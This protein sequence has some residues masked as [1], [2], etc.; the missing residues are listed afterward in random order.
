MVYSTPK[1]PRRRTNPDSSQLFLRI[2]ETLYGVN[3]LPCHPEV[4]GKAFQLYKDD[5]TRY[6]VVRTPHGVA[7]D[8]PDFVYRRAGLDPAGCKHVRALVRQGLLDDVVSVDRP[9]RRF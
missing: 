3:P 8:C 1:T 4:A 6:D 7:C 5:G 2:R 9:A